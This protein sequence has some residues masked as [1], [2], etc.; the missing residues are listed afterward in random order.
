MKKHLLLSALLSLGAYLAC[1]QTT[2]FHQDKAVFRSGPSTINPNWAPFYHGVASGDPLHDRVIIWTRV[3]PDEIGIE[4]IEVSWRMATDVDFENLVASGTF[5]TSAERDYT[6]KVDVEGLQAGTTYYYYFTVMNKNSLIGK[7]KTTPAT[8]QADQLKFG[9]VSCSNYQAGYFNAYQRLAERTDLD[10][11]IH[12]GDYIYEY[13]NGI[14]GDSNLFDIRLLEPGTEIIALE[15]YRSRYSTYRLDTCLARAHQQHAFIAVW[16]DHESANDAYVAGAQN[17]NEDTEGSWETRK[18]V[19]KQ[20]YFEWMP[21]RENDDTRVYRNISYGNLM[22]LIMLDT[23]LEGREEQILDV[24]DPA[25]LSTD[26]T[27]LGATQKAW[28]FDQLSQSN[29]KWKVIGQQVIVAEFN[30]GWA[31]LADPTFTFDQLESSFLDIWD[32]YPAERAEVLQYI[33]DNNIDNTVIL[34]GDFHSA[35]AFDVAPNPVNL[36]FQTIPGLGD[37][38]FYNPSAT[39]DAATGAGSVAVE[40]ATPSISSANFDE[41]TDLAT[42]QTL[43]FQINNPIEPFPGFS[44]GNPN[45]H[46]KYNNL[47]DHGYFILDVQDA[48][49]QADW[50]YGAINAVQSGESFD[51]GWK[52]ADGENHLTQAPTPSAPK[53]VQDTPAPNDPPQTGSGTKGNLG[54]KNFAL[55]SIY[56]NPTQQNQTLHFSLTAKEKVEIKLYNASGELVKTFLNQELHPGIFSL[57]VDGSELPKGTYIYQIRVGNSAYSAKVIWK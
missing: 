31:A 16:D 4:P 30:V 10:A 1:G 47:I 26:R 17:H 7:T 22:D 35:F 50:Y 32:G 42:A 5:S 39:Y 43:Q 49:V 2:L 33:A 8:D 27:L 23:R 37:F 11:I 56:P 14:Y 36:V 12:L 15:E 41:N 28:F 20:A 29:A 24:N 57:L 40:F 21:I 51:Q 3:T 6:V 55:L 53:P 38:P 44:L 45:P 52:T 18:A 46:L 19:A 25:L 34:T 9:V 54:E 48:Q 13:G